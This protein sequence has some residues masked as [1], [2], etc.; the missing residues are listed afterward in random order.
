MNTRLLSLTAL[1]LITLTFS[2]QLMASTP[3]MAI[4]SPTSP[5][6]LNT[7]QAQTL[8]AEATATYGIKGIEWFV[9]STSKRYTDY[10][11]S[12][13]YYKQE[14]YSLTFSSPGT[15]YVYDRQ[16]PQSQ[17]FVCWQV[18][19]TTPPPSPP[20]GVTASDGTYN[21]KFRVTWKS[22]SGATA[23]EV[24]RNT[25]NNSGSAHTCRSVIFPPNG[26]A[27]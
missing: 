4:M 19:V 8:N 3:T 25:S 1:F 5:V 11:G 10:T 17:A 14:S 26:Q 24:W 18:N 2:A 22:S 27:L 7:G 16:T 12:W 23:Y 20:T 21:D 15:F 13:I 9:G 6:S